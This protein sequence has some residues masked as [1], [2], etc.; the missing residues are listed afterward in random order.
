MCLVFFD[1]PT[2]RASELVLPERGFV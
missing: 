2:E 1:R